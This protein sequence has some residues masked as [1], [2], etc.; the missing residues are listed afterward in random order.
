MVTGVVL[1]G[2]GEPASS[3]GAAEADSTGTSEA[4]SAGG[5]SSTGPLLDVGSTPDLGPTQPVG[6]KGKIDFLFVISGQA[7][8]AEVQAQLLDAFPKF[9][10]TIQTKFADFDYHI[11]VVRGDP[12]W[13]NP[14]CN[15]NCSDTCMSFGYPCELVDTITACDQTWGSGVVFPAGSLASNKR[16]DL[17]DGRRYLTNQDPALEETFAC[18]AQLGESGGDALGASFAAAISPELGGPGGC[19][20]G[21]LRDDALLFV[22]FITASPDEDSP[23][24]PEEWA[25]AALAAKHD[26]PNAIVMFG[27]VDQLSQ[28]WC[29]TVEHNRVCRLIR[30]FPYWS[31]IDCDEPD[32]GP[33]FDLATDMIQDACDA[34]IPQ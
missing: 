33:G 14:G 1:P 8:M 7:F 10:D 34:F 2:T 30:K 18:V 26:D 28:A 22:S 17:P 11:M 12:F 25:E 3:T 13:G 20:E 16:C 32:Y 15:M 9:I 19:N 27:V 23:G 6:C 4:A 29:E 31:S 5:T 21:F 24:T